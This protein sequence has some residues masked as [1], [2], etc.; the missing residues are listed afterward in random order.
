MLSADS[1]YGWIS[2]RCCSQTNFL[3]CEE[4]KPLHIA[5]MWSYHYWVQYTCTKFRWRTSY[6]H[7]NT[8]ERRN[9]TLFYVCT[10][11]S[12]ILLTRVI[13]SQP[14]QKKPKSLPTKTR[15]LI[16]QLNISRNQLTAY[17]SKSFCFVKWKFLLGFFLE[18]WQNSNKIE[19]HE[20]VYQ[21]LQI[22]IVWQHT[23]WCYLIN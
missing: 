7:D 10:V 15:N 21:V 1:F 13:K 23:M 2:S 3:G 4:V 8:N 18:T 16:E 14:K 6:L 5:L 11:K 9:S 19:T 20:F 17:Y 22:V 12:E